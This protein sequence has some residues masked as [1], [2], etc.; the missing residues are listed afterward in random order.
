MWDAHMPQLQFSRKGFQ[1]QKLE[2]LLESLQL[3]KLPTRAFLALTILKQTA[4][5]TIMS[6]HF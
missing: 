2:K 3:L 5:S 6:L 1:L 4:C